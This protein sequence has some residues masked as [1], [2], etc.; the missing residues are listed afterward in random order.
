FQQIIDTSNDDK[1]VAARFYDKA[2]K[3]DAVTENGLPVFKNVTYV[4]IRLKDNS[5]EVFNQPATEAK[6]KR[7]PR[8][9]ALYKLSKEQIKDGTPLEQ[10]AFMT[11]AEVATCK[12]RGVFTVESLAGL[13]EDNVKDLCLQ[14]EHKL[15]C[16]FLK[17]AKENSAVAEF[18]R[19]ETSYKEEIAALKDKLSTMQQ[20]LNYCRGKK[21]HYQKG[22]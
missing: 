14:N 21:K 13:S 19:R 15:A 3:T 7:F 5:T 22:E 17:N 2:V 11:A 9:Y 20:E 16:I 12:N 4:E 8:E 10:F 6:I 18:A 1:N